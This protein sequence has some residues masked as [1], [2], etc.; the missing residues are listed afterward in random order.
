MLEH[1]LCGPG[2]GSMIV[3][4]SVHNERIERLWRDAFQGVL[5]LYCGLFHHLESMGCLDHNNSVHLFCLHYVYVPR[6]SRHLS[7]W[8]DAWNMHPLRTEQ[9]HTPLQ[10]WTRGLL[11]RSAQDLDDELLD[12]V[13]H[14]VHRP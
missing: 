13:W 14:V 7:T 9:N 1:P 12:E 3:G 8:T 2:R 5:K 11:T 10:L 4:T 6:I